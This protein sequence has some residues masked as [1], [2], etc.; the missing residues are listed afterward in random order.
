MEQDAHAP[1][2]RFLIMPVVSLIV[3]V[4]VGPQNLYASE[5][6]VRELIDEARRILVQPEPAHSDQQ[7]R[8][9]LNRGLQSVV[10]GLAGIAQQGDLDCADLLGRVAE[11]FKEALSVLLTVPPEVVD[12]RPDDPHQ[13]SRNACT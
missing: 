8:V 1:G 5:P 10:T 13:R 3:I 7:V 6:T 12:V 9:L 2:L 11:G 4:P